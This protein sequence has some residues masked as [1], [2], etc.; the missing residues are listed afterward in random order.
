M[1]DQQAILVIDRDPVSLVQ[2]RSILDRSGYRTICAEK[3]SIGISIAQTCKP[4]LALVDYATAGSEGLVHH[5]SALTS[6]TPTIFLTDSPQPHIR[7]MVYQAGGIDYMSKPIVGQEVIAKVRANLPADLH[8]RTADGLLPQHIA[9]SLGPLCQ[10][11]D[12][13]IQVV[14]L[15]QTDLYL[16]ADLTS[17]Q[18]TKPSILTRIQLYMARNVSPQI[19][20]GQLFNL[21]DHILSDTQ[22][23]GIPA[24]IMRLDKGQ[25]HL[26]LICAGL[27]PAVVV[28]PCSQI[29]FLGGQ[30]SPMGL[31]TSAK[32]WTGS[33]W[34]HDRI[35]AYSHPVDTQLLASSASSHMGLP[36]CRATEAIRADLACGGSILEQEAALLGIQV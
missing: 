34:Q 28:G 11:D 31:G 18:D 15:D 33:I 20:A 8:P 25:G 2:L 16:F 30:D 9:L 21:L 3:A 23:A 12:Y 24:M 35:F 36:I 10:K 5:G 26:E 6:G 14:S 13:L 7:T 27:G 32:A 17:C 22:P 19:G 4:S 1:Q 29:R